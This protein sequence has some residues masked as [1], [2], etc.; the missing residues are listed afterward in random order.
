MLPQ[1]RRT[2]KPQPNRNAAVVASKSPTLRTQRHRARGETRRTLR[3]RIPRCSAFLRVLCVSALAWWRVGAILAA[4]EDCDGLQ[5]RETIPGNQSLRPSRLGG[6][7]RLR[8][9]ER[10]FR[11]VRAQD[12]GKWARDTF[13]EPLC[14]TSQ[15]LS[16]YLEDTRELVCGNARTNFDSHEYAENISDRHFPP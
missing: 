13:G 11:C 2:A 8:L 12:A 10:P 3:G 15:E 14:R 1:I 4:R 6:F 16:V 7:L 9:R 5:C